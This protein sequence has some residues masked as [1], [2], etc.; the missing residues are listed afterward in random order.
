MRTETLNIEKPTGKLLDFVRKLKTD[1]EATKQALIN[2][3][4]QYFP[5]S[6]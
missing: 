4:D 6:I 1:K 2:K 3:K 5:K